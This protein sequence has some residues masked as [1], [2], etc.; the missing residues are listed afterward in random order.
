MAPLEPFNNLKKWPISVALQS[1]LD[2]I[3]FGFLSKLNQH[4][5]DIRLDRKLVKYIVTSYNK[6]SH[7]FEFNGIQFYFSLIDVYLLT[8]LPVSGEPVVGRLNESI[9]LFNKAFPTFHVDCKAENMFRKG[10]LLTSWLRDKF[11]SLEVYEGDALWDEYRRAFMLWCIAS[12]IVP[13]AS[14]GVIE[15]EY[16]TMLEDLENVGK[17]AWGAAAWTTMQRQLKTG[18]LNG[19]SCALLVNLIFFY[20][21]LF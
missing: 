18:N 2:R 12:Y 8:G 1:W 19:M 13:D 10:K 15:I 14:T 3:G 11:S 4:K 9:I 5:S 20:F 16:T 7:C 21:F 6:D 17:Y